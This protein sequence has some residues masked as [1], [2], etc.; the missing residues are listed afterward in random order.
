MPWL[1]Q[2]SYPLAEEDVV[3]FAFGNTAYDN[4]KPARPIQ[5]AAVTILMIF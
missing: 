3:S 5:Y 4:D 1:S 2:E